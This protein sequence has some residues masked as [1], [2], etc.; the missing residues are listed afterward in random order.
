MLRL[1]GRRRH[2]ALLQGEPLHG[3]NSNTFDYGIYTYICMYTYICTHLSLSIYIYIHM[4]IFIM[5]N[6]SN[7]VIQ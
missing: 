5:R 2:Q 1:R 7:T 6:H 3:N 4:Y